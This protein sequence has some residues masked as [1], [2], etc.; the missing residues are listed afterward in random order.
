MDKWYRDKYSIETTYD[1]AG[2]F[3]D[4]WKKL[5]GQLNKERKR[6]KIDENTS[7]HIG[8]FLS[9]KDQPNF[10][11]RPEPKQQDGGHKS[12]QGENTGWQ[13]LKKHLAQFK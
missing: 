2:K 10:I 13:R 3:D 8:H 12:H 7:T 5:Q 9:S 4:G 11:N 6:Q 1:A